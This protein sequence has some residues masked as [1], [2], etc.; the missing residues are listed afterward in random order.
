ME[1]LVSGAQKFGIG[2]LAALGLVGAGMIAALAAIVLN[3]SAQPMQMLYS[4]IDP[5]DASG[6][7]AALDQA[8][9]KHKI[10]ADGTAIMVPRDKVGAGR[11]LLAGKGL[12]NAGA[13]GYS[14]FD[15]QSVLGQTDAQQKVNLIRALDGEL[16]N[17]IMAMDG[18]TYANVLINQP[19]H[20]LFENEPGKPSASVTIGMGGRKATPEM[21]Q[22]VQNLVA[23][24]V[25]GMT[26]EMVTVVDKKGVLLSAANDG[27]LSATLADTRKAQVEA[28]YRARLTDLV[29]KI[30]GPGNARVEVSADLDL[31]S[32]SE[33]AN[34][35]NP[36]A[37]VVQSEQSVEQ[38]SKDTTSNANTPV[39]AASNTPTGATGGGSDT[40]DNSSGSTQSTTN[41]LNSNT[42][43]TKVTQ[44]GA[45]KRLSVSVV[46]NNIPGPVDPKTGVAGKSTARDPQ[47]IQQIQ[48]AVSAAMGFDQSRGDQ[49]KVTNI[50]FESNATPID[51]KAK[52]PGILAGFGKNDIMRLVELVV[53]AVVAVL[54]LLLGVKPLIK[55]LGLDTK[56]VHSMASMPMLT[57]AGGQAMSLAS[58][59]GTAG[60]L[61]H[62]IGPNGETL[63][64][65]GPESAPG[66]DM[67]R[68]EGQV[69]ASSVKQVAE[70]VEKHPEESVSILRSWLHETA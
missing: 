40:A 11:I 16:R 58:G 37:Q 64:I 7:E 10:N 46:V 38:N 55:A 12:L 54:I 49:L 35:Y 18:V 21:V 1:A 32:V 17:N 15:G 63:A 51:P 70:F 4:G 36:D 3:L 23:S 5:K 56:V 43:T 47:Q 31:T 60:G 6:M 9:I 20:Q 61:Q 52:G 24:A 30:V 13:A 26:P 44:P 33:T 34:L 67:A 45:T 66:I 59:G 48:D 69:K 14:L 22:A 50:A 2:K 53:L 28:D 8:G 68:I 19:E 27:Q 29:E 65:A 41:Y 25:P 62:A 39:T 42:V 57:G